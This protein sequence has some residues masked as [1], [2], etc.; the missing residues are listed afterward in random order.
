MS[1]GHTRFIDAWPD[2]PDGN[3]RYAWPDSPDGNA[4][5]IGRHGNPMS[6][7]RSPAGRNWKRRNYW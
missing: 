2:S 5:Y 1:A 7:P 6:F 4:R 3:A